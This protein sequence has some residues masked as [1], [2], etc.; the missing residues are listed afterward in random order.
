MQ[1]LDRD[2]GDQ[3]AL[4][5]IEGV[6]RAVETAKGVIET[7]GEASGEE[8]AETEAA[9]HAGDSPVSGARNSR[10]A[11]L[12]G[13]TGHERIE[14]NLAGAEEIRLRGHDHFLVGGSREQGCG[15]GPRR[16]EGQNGL[17]HF[18]GVS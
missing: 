8:V 18:Q 10:P 2:A 7:D 9:T 6:P 13:S 15:Q 5:V 17:G 1:A 12:P 3:I 11:E 16:A 14:L 4:K